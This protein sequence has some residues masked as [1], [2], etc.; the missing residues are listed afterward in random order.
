MSNT[1]LDLSGFLDPLPAS[2]HVVRESDPSVAKLRLRLA[3]RG[4]SAPLLLLRDQLD[5]A[6]TTDV[7]DALASE[8]ETA[9][10]TRPGLWFLSVPARRQELASREHSELLAAVDALDQTDND[11]PMRQAFALALDSDGPRLKDIPTPVIV[12]LTSARDWLGDLWCLPYDATELASELALR[13]LD[14][15]LKKMTKERMVGAKHRQAL[16]TLYDFAK[17]PEKAALSVSYV[18]GGG[19]SGKTT[20]LAFLHDR[21]RQEM[22]VVRIDFD[23]PAIDARRRMTL[24]LALC[25]QLAGSVRGMDRRLRALREIAALQIGSGIS[26]AGQRDSNALDKRA[27]SRESYTSDSVSDEASILYAMLEDTRGPIA[28]IFDTAE[29]VLA[30]SDTHASELAGWLEFLHVEAKARD[31]RIVIAGR[32]PQNAGEAGV[33]LIARLAARGAAVQ[34]SIALPELTPDEAV[35]LLRTCGLEDEAMIK[36]AAQAVPGNPLLLRITGDA[37]KQGDAQMREAVRQA[38]RE[39]QI[40]PESAKNYLLRRVVAHVSDPFARPYVLAA[41]FSPYFSTEFLE[42][43]V[44]P[45]ADRQAGLLQQSAPATDGDAR[46][47]ATN[48]AERVFRALAGTHWLA[49]QTLAPDGWVAFNPDSRAFALKLMA[50]TDDGMALERDLRQ[51]AAIYHLTRTTP[52]DQALALYH[53]AVLGH[54]IALPQNRDRT[55]DLLADVLQEL[56]AYLREWLTVEPQPLPKAEAKPR[57]DVLLRANPKMNASQWARYLEGYGD[58]PGEGGKLVDA[59]HARDALELYMDRPTRTAGDVPTFVL[60]ALADLGDWDNE[61][62]NVDEIVRLGAQHWLTTKELASSEI[63]RIYWL[64]R[65]AL[66]KNDGQLERQHLDVLRRV[67]ADRRGAKLTALTALVCVAEAVRG[68][69]FMGDLMRDYALKVEISP[70]VVL[71]A[72]M[73]PIAKRVSLE[74]GE[75]A[76]AQSDWWERVAELR[77]AL[78]SKADMERLR[79]ARELLLKLK[80]APMSQVNIVFSRLRERIRVQPLALDDKSRILLLRG[81]TIE[82]HRPLREALLAYYGD[83]MAGGVA[84]SIFGPTLERM[85]IRPAEMESSAF[86]LRIESN[87]R[88]WCTAFVSYADRCRLLPGL[89][90]QLAEHGNPKAAR[91]AKSFLTWDRALCGGRLSQWGQKEKGHG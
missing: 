52:V 47:T 77:L 56:P 40:D 53:R 20:L 29:L 71:T 42:E 83:G 79:T 73:P 9:V 6:V 31:L 84:R 74:V 49:R 2:T 85:T 38:H 70:R 23:D 34:E 54:R 90:E 91:I 63:W 59:D 22:P 36:Q 30:R 7:L 41:T 13:V 82:F 50:V 8:V 46:K 68:E 43:V 66:L 35:E 4:W 28:I 72:W 65:F 5:P 67:S 18:Y 78:T 64:T 61:I 76:V 14:S 37:L 17:R 55:R 69:R 44:I 58:K 89:C 1:V 80:A 24:T 25:E 39:S 45:C 15:N 57:S 51:S 75:V 32:D 62:A 11:D 48:K 12:A 26:R 3:V 27:Q 87:P 86:Y 60:Q 33:N 81:A 16:E 10:E 88:A 19:G 21:L